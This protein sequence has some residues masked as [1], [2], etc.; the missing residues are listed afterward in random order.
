MD[1]GLGSRKEALIRVIAILGA[2]GS[3]QALNRTMLEHCRMFVQM[4]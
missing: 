3:K 2:M 1:I 4:Y